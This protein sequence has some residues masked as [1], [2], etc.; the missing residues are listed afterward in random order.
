MAKIVDR[1]E[2]QRLI[3]QGVRL[4]E[5]L[6]VAGLMCALIGAFS[7]GL[8]MYFHKNIGITGTYYTLMIIAPFVVLGVALVWWLTAR[9]VRKSEGIDL[10]LVYKAIPPD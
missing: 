8:I 5:V 10:D 9:W 1:A 6:P 3:G 4:V 2:V 7:I